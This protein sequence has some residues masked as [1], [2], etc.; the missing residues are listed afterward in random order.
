MSSSDLPPRQLLTPPEESDAFSQPPLHPPPHPSSSTSSNTQPSSSTSSLTDWEV[1]RATNNHQT[2]SPSI[3]DSNNNER[4]E[5]D[6]VCELSS[7]SS[8]SF[9]ALTHS[10]V[11]ASNV[12]RE[13]ENVTSEE[14]ERYRIREEE[15][16]SER[17]R[18]SDRMEEDG[19]GRG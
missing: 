17:R 2:G 14:R 12:A 6:S 11:I 19:N 1:Y 8:S 16:S 18:E 4:N 15:I 13:W 7:S 3:Q 5:I 9:P 10:K